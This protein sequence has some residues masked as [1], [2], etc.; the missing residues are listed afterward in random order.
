MIIAYSFTV[1]DAWQ[2]SNEEQLLDNLLK[3]DKPKTEPLL[4][5]I[6]MHGEWQRE[7]DTTKAIPKALG[8]EK[9][10]NPT[11]ELFLQRLIELDDGLTVMLRGK[12]DCKDGA[13]AY[14][15]KTGKK[16]ANDY[17]ADS[18]QHKVYQ[19]LAP[20]LNE[21]VYRC[22]NQYT[23]EVTAAQ[24]ELD[25][26]SLQAGLQFCIENS[27]EITNYL[28]GRGLLDQVVRLQEYGVKIGLNQIDAATT[29]KAATQ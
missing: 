10:N 15:W 25:D 11:T 23:G 5:G 29:I 19:V 27:R 18:Y 7:V 2:N 1:F 6:K 8:G 17:V 9:L 28:K 24:V 26:A 3:R 13:T 12:L 22:L 16:P 14:D 20:E 4:F 21:F